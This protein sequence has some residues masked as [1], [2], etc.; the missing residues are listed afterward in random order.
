MKRIA[1]LGAG[2]WG[3]V[4]ANVLADN[5]HDVTIWARNEDVTKEINTIH[6]NQAYLGDAVL[7]TNLKAHTSLEIVVRGKEVVL[8]A[9]PSHA[10]R[11]T[12]IQV[13]PHVHTDALLIH[14]TKGFEQES[15]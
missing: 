9:V 15:W 7:H 14:A 6:R 5:G 12:L 10:M 8:F 3:T 1:V 4:L 11:E 13:K 2:S